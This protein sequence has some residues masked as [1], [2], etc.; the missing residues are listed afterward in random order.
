MC[1]SRVGC[2]VV[3]VVQAWLWWQYDSWTSTLR[4]H[5]RLDVKLG[6]S[7]SVS[8]WRWVWHTAVDSC[9]C[10]V[11]SARFDCGSEKP[12]VSF[13][14]QKI[15]ALI[16][17]LKCCMCLLLLYFLPFTN[18]PLPT[19]LKEKFLWVS[20]FPGFFR[21]CTSSGG[22]RPRWLSLSSFPLPQSLI[23]LFLVVLLTPLLLT[24]CVPHCHTF[25]C[26]SLSLFYSVFFFSVSH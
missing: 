20:H 5:T 10:H 7:A 2:G 18:C 15:A 23:N 16:S 17:L 26:H 19:I 6:S 9:S 3:T 25:P 14:V 4:Q 12:P 1:V 11:T 22:A 21:D 8:G 13:T 24:L